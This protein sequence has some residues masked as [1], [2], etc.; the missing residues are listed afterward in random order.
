MELMPKILLIDDQGIVR[1]AL[2][3]VLTHASYEVRTAR[4]GPEGLELL[5]RDPP[6]LIILDRDLPVMTGSQVLREIRKS[7]PSVRVMILTGWAEA[8]GQ[9]KYLQLGVETIL[10][11][12]VGIEVLLKVIERELEKAPGL[13]R[14][15]ERA[16]GE[17]LSQRRVLVAD[18]DPGVQTVLNRF[19]KSK[20]YSVW[21]AA[22][23]RQALEKE[24][25]FKPH[26]V[27][28]DIDMP[29]LDG[30]STLR[31]LREL[32]RPLGIIMIS[33]AENAETARQ[34]LKEGASDF[35]AKPFNFDYLELSVW[36]KIL[37][38]AP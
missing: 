1:D 25:L 29:V 38:I 27:L 20:G 28:L 17:A 12:G 5:R 10:S 2:K 11:K 34:C 15:P 19:L 22:D 16:G 36:A 18:D 30:L 3:A 7:H 35:I 33:G 31:R 14:E 26:L 21:S 9:E 23:G 6:D 8:E 4:S 24:L 32:N 13:R 37:T